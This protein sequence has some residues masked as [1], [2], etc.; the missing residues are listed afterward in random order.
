MR[1]AAENS[2]ETEVKA[3]AGQ[4]EK[5]WERFSAGTELRFEALARRLAHRSPRG[6]QPTRGGG[7]VGAVDVA[8]LVDRKP[9]EQVE[10]QECSLTSCQR[11]DGALEAT[12]EQVDVGRPEVS[13]FGIVDGV[14]ER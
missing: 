2:R 9:I 12:F 11:A 5:G 6:P 4:R 1:R 10:S 3:T 8:N 13:E 14:E 7:A